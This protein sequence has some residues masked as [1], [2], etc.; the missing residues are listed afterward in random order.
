M[1]LLY[2]STYGAVFFCQLTI[3]VNFI[4]PVILVRMQDLKKYDE[5]NLLCRCF[6]LKDGCFSNIYG[7]W[8]EATLRREEK[9]YSKD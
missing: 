3:V 6:W 9:V 4:C 1:A 8:D 5:W 2:L 7:P